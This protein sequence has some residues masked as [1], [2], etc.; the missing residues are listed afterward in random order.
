V[1]GIGL[2]LGLYTTAKRFLMKK[3]TQRYPEELPELPPRSRGS[4]GF[5]AD[6]CISCGLCVDVCPNDV[7][8]VDYFTG[9]KN[10]RQLEKYTMNLGYCLFCGLCVEICPKDAVFFKTDFDLACYRKDD[11]VFTWKGSAYRP[12]PGEPPV[13]Q[14]GKGE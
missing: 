4:F 11:T 3:V 5:N 2:A 14:D 9:D 10:R 1:F 13:P 7:I 8:R 12:A 6:T